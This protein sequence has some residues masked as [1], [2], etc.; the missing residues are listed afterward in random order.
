MKKI[1]ISPIASAII[2]AV[3]GIAFIVFPLGI[4]G[5]VLRIVGAALLIYEILRVIPLIKSNAGMDALLLFLISDIF[6]IVFALILLINPL[7]A[8]RT[9]S[10]ILG[11]YLMISAAVELYKLSRLPFIGWKLCI[12]PTVTLIIGVFL[13]CYPA[14]ATEVTLIIIGATIIVRA[15]DVLIYEIVGKKHTAKKKRK[16]KPSIETKDYRDVS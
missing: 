6:A 10:I 1:V 8:L 14:T 7:G 5:T 15:I 4:I 16:S 12:M 13:V 9:L 11:V 3:F 2:L